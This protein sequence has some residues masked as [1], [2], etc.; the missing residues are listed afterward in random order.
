MKE[1][2]E[3]EVEIVKNCVIEVVEIEKL[4]EIEI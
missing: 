2:E 4:W 3:C 1:W